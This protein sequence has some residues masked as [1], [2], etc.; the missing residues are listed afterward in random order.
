MTAY[1]II[2]SL[3][4]RGNTVIGT[5]C[6]AAAIEYRSDTSK[7]IKIGNNTTD[8]WLDYYRLI[9]TPNQ[10]NFCVP[11]VYSMYIDYAN[12]FYVCTMERLSQYDGYY[13]YENQ[14]KGIVEDYV[15]EKITKDEFIDKAVDYPKA[16]PSIGSMLHILDQIIYH[17]NYEEGDDIDVVKRVD[18]HKSNI[19]S[20]I[21][22]ALVITDPWCHHE[23]VMEDM[24]DMEEWAAKALFK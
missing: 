4:R 3:S 10:H 7:I 6:Y 16:I 22:G 20:R 21:S 18:L 8:P 12:S 13:Q 9:V 17:S 11:K 24:D 19:L 15:L 1:N 2:K 5:G 14:A 23:E